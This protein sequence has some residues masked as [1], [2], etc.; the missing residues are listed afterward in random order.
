MEFFKVLRTAIRSLASSVYVTHLILG[1]IPAPHY[2]NVARAVTSQL[3]VANSNL[4]MSVLRKYPLNPSHQLPH[5]STSIFIQGYK[6]PPTKLKKFKFPKKCRLKSFKFLY[7][8]CKIRD[9]TK[10]NILGILILQ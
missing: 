4:S 9:K 1:K 6:F 2:G 8:V 3:T 7:G 10:N 5:T